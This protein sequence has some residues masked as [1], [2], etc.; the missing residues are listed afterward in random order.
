MRTRTFCL[1]EPQANALQAAYLHC[2]E[3]DT[4]IRYQAVRLYGLGYAVPQIQDICGCSRSR[5]LAWVQAYRERG[6]TALLDHRQGGNRARL[7]PDQIEALQNQLHRYTPV[8]LL[9]KESWRGGGQFWTI[10][11]LATL[12]TREYEVTF[13]SQTS[14]RSLLETCGFSYQRPAKQYKSHNDVKVLDFEQALEK[15]L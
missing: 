5:L 4:K 10:A 13:A 7:T 3:A 9:G 14:Y 12:L 2:S 1:T 11:D 6:V 15:K 8:Q